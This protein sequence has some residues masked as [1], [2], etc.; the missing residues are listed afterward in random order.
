[1][2]RGEKDE[3][4]RECEE[5]VIRKEEEMVSRGRKGQHDRVRIREEEKKVNIK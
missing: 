4:E 5:V 3:M 2:K 1:M